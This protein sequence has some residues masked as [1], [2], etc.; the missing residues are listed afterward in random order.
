VPHQ[1]GKSASTDLFLPEFIHRFLPDRKSLELILDN[2]FFSRERR[3][4]LEV[5]LALVLNLVRPGERVGYQKVIDRFFSETGLAFSQ[6]FGIKPPDKAAF[7]RARQ[8]IPAKVFQILFTA[9]VDYAQALAGQHDKLTWQGFRVCAIDGT[10]KTLPA[11]DELSDMFEAPRNAHFPQM[12]IGVLFDVLAK[13]PLNYLRAPFNTSE[14]DMAL[15]LLAELGAGD[16]LLLDRG[17][18]GYRLLYAIITQGADFLV[19]LPQIGLFR[20]ARNFLAHGK[21]DGKITIYP[22]AALLRKH[23]HKTWPPLTLRL[24][25]VALP[26]TAPDAVFITTLLDSKKFPRR[27]FR[28]LYHHRW[29]EEEFFKTI[30]EHLRAEEFHGN[31]V[32]FIDQELLST[33]LYYVLTR[34][35]MLEAARLYNLPVATLET[36]AALIA[37]GRYLDRLWLA[38]SLDACRDLLKRC[39]TE[40]SWRTYQPRPGRKFPRLSKSRHGKWA[41]KWPQ[42]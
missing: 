35:L 12:A 6:D 42:A 19:R 16:L 14:R 18:P 30:K 27:A 15:E 40:I 3:L 28:N 41:N 37:V 7:S 39:L 31:T 9:A 22:P 13:L 25:K 36:K 29:A 34:I 38:E 17:F 4:S 32:R 20:E 10:K 11:S 1:G 21:W 26:G 5:T 24:V 8:K 23:P 2:R 33:Y